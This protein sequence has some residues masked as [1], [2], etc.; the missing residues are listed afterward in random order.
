LTL[1]AAAYQFG[2]ATEAKE[3]VTQRRLGHGAAKARA[4]ER[5]TRRLKARD[6]T[7]GRRGRSL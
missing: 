2:S 7:V 3:R 1:H 4:K 6:Q 5:V